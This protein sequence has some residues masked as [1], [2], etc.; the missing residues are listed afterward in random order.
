VN[1]APH[2]THVI[3][4]V[5]LYGSLAEPDRQE[6]TDVDLIVHTRRRRWDPIGNRPAGSSGRGSASVPRWPS[7]ERVLTERA[8]LHALLGASH[9]RL[10]IAVVDE[11]S[12]DQSLLPPGSIQKCVFP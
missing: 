1:R 9:D 10:D 3:E 12:D 2:A 8:A 4:S 11:L 5:L 6:V 7:E